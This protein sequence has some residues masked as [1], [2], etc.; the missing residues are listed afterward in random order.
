VPAGQKIRLL[1]LRRPRGSF[2]E[3]LLG[4]YLGRIVERALAA[5]DLMQ[6]QAREDEALEPLSE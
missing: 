1:E 5:P 4:G 3:R 6:V 2:V